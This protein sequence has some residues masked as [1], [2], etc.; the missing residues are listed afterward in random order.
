[1]ELLNLENLQE[2]LQEFAVEVRNLY[3]DNLIRH[4]RIASG[5][6]LNSV[7]ARVETEDSAYLV[8]L[9]LEEYWKYVENDTPPHWPP[10]SAILNWIMVKPILPR[11]DGRIPTPQSL[12]YL[13]GRAMAGK[14]PNQL[15][16]KNPHGGTTGT[17]DLEDAKQATL[18]RFRE[19]ITHALAED[20]GQ[21]IKLVLPR[22]VG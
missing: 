14:S 13:I 16:L 20:L 1:M 21:Y 9:R 15:N 10:Q 17:H 3:Q 6:L 12:A 19:R 22:I 5:G 2:V 18:L 11:R 8:Q 7:E 4:D